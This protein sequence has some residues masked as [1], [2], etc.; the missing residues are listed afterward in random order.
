MNGKTIKFVKLFFL[1]HASDGGRVIAR[2]VD[3]SAEVAVHAQSIFFTYVA[4]AGAGVGVRI[5]VRGL[6]SR[7]VLPSAIPVT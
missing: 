1:K 5:G 2:C 4:C 6:V 7:E 3:V